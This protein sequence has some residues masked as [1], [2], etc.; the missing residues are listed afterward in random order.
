MIDEKDRFA[1]WKAEIDEV[2]IGHS[3]MSSPLNPLLAVDAGTSDGE[4]YFPAALDRGEVAALCA[5]LQHV[6]ADWPEDKKP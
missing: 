2:R 3:Y 1:S 6:L 4:D 5:H